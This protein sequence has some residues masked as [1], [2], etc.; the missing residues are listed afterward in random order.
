[1]VDA[2]KSKLQKVKKNDLFAIP[3]CLFFL[4]APLGY[5]PRDMMPLGLSPNVLP[6]GI[7]V[8][9]FIVF[10][11]LKAKV[12]ATSGFVLI[13]ICIMSLSLYTGRNA[14]PMMVSHFGY[15]LIA[16]L[17]ANYRYGENEIRL[18]FR[19]YLCSLIIV[20]G[21]CFIELFVKTLDGFK[22]RNYTANSNN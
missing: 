5:L 4:I 12:N 15:F 22:I 9:I 21:M 10:F 11:G 16:L 2:R 3:L 19:V 17:A 8:V 6:A 13:Y 20:V 7:I 1:M 18:F 14:A